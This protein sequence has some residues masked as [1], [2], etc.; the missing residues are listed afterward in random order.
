M[1]RRKPIQFVTILPPKDAF[2]QSCIGR[3]NL[4]IRSTN[5][6]NFHDREFGPATPY[7]I[8]AVEFL[9]IEEQ[10]SLAQ[11]LAERDG[12]DFQACLVSI[13]ENGIGIAVQYCSLVVQQTMPFPDEDHQAAK[14]DR[15]W[16]R[17]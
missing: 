1:A 16:D 4:P 7:Y 12:I 3:T 11:W 2:F 6:I 14:R 5:A 17:P 9:T 8:I 15:W 13:R 10:D